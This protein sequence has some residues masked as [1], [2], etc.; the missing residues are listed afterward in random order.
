MK[1][2]RMAKKEIAKVTHEIN[3]VWHMKYKGLGIGVIQT[4]TN[5]KDSPS[6]EY[7]FINHG[8]NWYEFIDKRPTADRR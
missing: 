1:K 4:H 8:F 5:K 6:Y 2:L 3:N 7:V